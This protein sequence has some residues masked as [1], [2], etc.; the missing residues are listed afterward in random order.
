MRACLHLPCPTSLLPVHSPPFCTAQEQKF[1]DQARLN[2]AFVPVAPDRS[3]F[4]QALYPSRPGSRVAQAVGASALAAAPGAGGTGDTLSPGGGPRSPSPTP[5]GGM[6]GGGGTGAGTGTSSGAGT[7][8]ASA[9]AGGSGNGGICQHPHAWGVRSP[10]PSLGAGAGS[11]TGPGSAAVITSASGL[12]RVSAGAWSGSAGASAGTGGGAGA[13]TG[14]R[15]SFDLSGSRQA[16]SPSPVPGGSPSLPTSRAWRQTPAFGFGS[17]AAAPFGWGSGVSPGAALSR[18]VAAG[19]STTALN[20]SGFAGGVG[21]GAVPVPGLPQA[22]AGLLTPEVAGVLADPRSSWPGLSST[23]GTAT[24]IGIGSSIGGAPQ[25]PHPQPSSQGLSASGAAAGAGATQSSASG[26]LPALPHQHQH[27]HQQPPQP[28]RAATSLGF[29]REAQLATAAAAAALCAPGTS[30]GRNAVTPEPGALAGAMPTTAGLSQPARAG[31]GPMPGPIT[32]AWVAQSKSGVNELVTPH[33][34]RE[35][36]LKKLGSGAAA[37]AVPVAAAGGN[38]GAAIGAGAGEGPGGG[39]GASGGG[40][41]TGSPRQ[42]PAAPGAT[43][44]MGVA[45]LT[46]GSGTGAGPSTA[47]SLVTAAPSAAAQLGGSRS[48]LN[49][50]SS[51][52]TASSAGV[53]AGHSSG[54]RSIANGGNSFSHGPFLPVARSPATGASLSG[55]AAAA[56]VGEIVSVGPAPAV[57]TGSIS[58]ADHDAAIR[59][60]LRPPRVGSRA[61][62]APAVSTSLAASAPVAFAA[63]P[64]ATVTEAGDEDQLLAVLDMDAI[65]A[66]AE[67]ANL[68]ASAGAVP[69]PGRG[70]SG[71]SCG[72]GGLPVSRKPADGT[73]PEPMAPA[74]VRPP[75]GTAP[76]SAGLPPPPAHRTAV[77]SPLPGAAPAAATAPAGAAAAS[78]AGGGAAA[79]SQES[80]RRAT[81][82]PERRGSSGA[83]GGTSSRP[84]SRALLTPASPLSLVPLPPHPHQQHPHP[85]HGAGPSHDGLLNH[86][87]ASPHGAPATGAALPLPPHVAAPPAP[88]TPAGCNVP[89]SPVPALPLRP[90]S[91]GGSYLPRGAYMN[92]S[93]VGH[94]GGGGAGGGGRRPSA[95]GAKGGG[96]RWSGRGFGTGT[97][98]GTG[99]GAAN[100]DAG[101][102]GAGAGAGAGERPASAARVALTPDAL[103]GGGGSRRRIMVTCYGQQVDT[104]PDGAVVV[105]PAPATRSP[106]SRGGSASGDRYVVNAT[107]VDNS[108]GAVGQPLQT[109]TPTPKGARGGRA[110]AAAAAA[111]AVAA[112]AAAHAVPLD[113]DLDQY[114]AQQQAMQDPDTIGA[115]DRADLD[116][117]SA[118]LADV[119]ALWPVGTAPNA[120]HNQPPP[121]HLHGHHQ[122][123]GSRQQLYPQQHAGQNPQHQPQLPLPYRHAGTPASPQ[124]QPAQPAQPPTRY[125]QP[126]LSP[127]PLAAG[128]H[129]RAYTP[130][131][132]AAARPDSGASNLPAAHASPAGGVGAT[133]SS[134]ERVVPVPMAGSQRATVDGRPPS[135]VAPTDVAMEHVPAGE[136]G[137]WGAAAVSPGM[138]PRAATWQQG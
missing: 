66:D 32:R 97:V 29:A 74:G 59:S 35:S 96:Q 89:P 87:P 109:P 117:Q 30:G 11:W 22:L 21:G 92:V 94:G 111:G 108:G 114:M 4:K 41:G 60:R 106:E 9:S 25:E 115:G 55:A 19:A 26:S 63:L 67:V 135:R 123:P 91:P 133:G 46:A 84:P 31:A 34:Q 47:G 102:A 6:R 16:M 85:Q 18:G 72:S 61:A 98:S 27:Q 80:L 23:A 137:P 56:L 110:A 105:P 107:L 78:T 10:S 17:A 2:A 119:A 54:S 42:L 136:L 99:T 125:H 1:D 134:A 62:T 39:G 116:R 131:S 112:A 121:L 103:L 14:V 82:S 113:L 45:G 127:Q 71:G 79:V 101:A 40:S 5:M 120:T 68:S 124:A 76:G 37:G 132:T 86:R 24:G 57:V 81:V 128:G 43:S 20:A 130:P 75:P 70:G 95:R 118:G 100:S 15:R 38:G 13:S 64:M 3:D 53:A 138:G 122:R 77:S 129:R 49:L 88:S 33:T 7:G 90:A 12:P 58:A 28:P 8:N 50:G 126:R 93:N 51:T 83:I 48:R 44:P 65:L 104:A 69:L 36:S 73:Y 52:P